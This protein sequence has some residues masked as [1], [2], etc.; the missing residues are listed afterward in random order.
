MSNI[1]GTSAGEDLIGSPNDDLIQ[2]LGGDDG[3]NGLKGNDVLEGG[4]GLDSA[5]FE[6]DDAPA[7]GVSVSLA[8]GQAVDQWGGTDTLR[9]EG[10]LTHKTAVA[11]VFKLVTAASKTWRRLSG[12][13]RLSQDQGCR[14]PR[15]HRGE[16]RRPIRRS[17]ISPSSNIGRSAKKPANSMSC[18]VFKSGAAGEI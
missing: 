4:D 6:S 8:T 1:S 14:V 3:L 12:N 7:T 17:L 5:W 2:G 15:R 9:T 11:M 16:A 10:C 13:T 18:E